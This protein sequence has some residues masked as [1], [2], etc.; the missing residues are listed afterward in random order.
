MEKMEALL[1][2]TLKMAKEGDSEALVS[3]EVEN[4]LRKEKGQPTIEEALAEIAVR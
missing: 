1:W 2:A 3:L 4:R